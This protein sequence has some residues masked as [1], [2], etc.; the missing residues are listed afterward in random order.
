MCDTRRALRGFSGDASTGKPRDEQSLTCGYLRASR[1]QKHDLPTCVPH[2]ISSFHN[3]S[4][5]R[6]QIAFYANGPVGSCFEECR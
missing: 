4:K 3:V 5:I 6:I 1:S 2:C